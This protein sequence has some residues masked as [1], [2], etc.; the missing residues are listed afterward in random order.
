MQAL[1]SIAGIEALR[2]QREINEILGI[3]TGEI[4]IKKRLGGYGPEELLRKYLFEVTDIYPRERL[5]EMRRGKMFVRI[6]YDDTGENF[7]VEFTH[8]KLGS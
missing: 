3:L 6:A 7:D 2:C 1:N 5:L 8:R 4:T